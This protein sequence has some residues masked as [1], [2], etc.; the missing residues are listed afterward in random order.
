MS[1]SLNLTNIKTEVF[2]DIYLFE[3]NTYTSIRDIFLKKTDTNI[4][5]GGN[6]ETLQNNLNILE[7]N[8][9]VFSSC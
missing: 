4:V 3:D 9:D 7:E 2:N 6:T 5:G 8:L 1:S